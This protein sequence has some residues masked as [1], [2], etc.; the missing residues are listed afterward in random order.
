METLFPPFSSHGRKL[1]LSNPLKVLAPASEESGAPQ[2]PPG[3]PP[4]P[5]PKPA[6]TSVR[7]GHQP[8]A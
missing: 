6:A 2:P 8:V 3:Q 7:D 5:G 1:G 4:A